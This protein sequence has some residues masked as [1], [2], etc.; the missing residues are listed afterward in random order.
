MADE[1]KDK[2]VVASADFKVDDL[3]SAFNDAVETQKA[4]Q[5]DD[6]TE[7]LN[8]LK[9]IV[10]TALKVEPEAGQKEKEVDPFQ[11]VNDKYAPKKDEE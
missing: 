1:P 10:D 6:L 7:A 5:D 8:K 11:K 9:D 2:V 3:T 4:G